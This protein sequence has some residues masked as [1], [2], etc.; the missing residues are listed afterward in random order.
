MSRT[1]QIEL[2]SHDPEIVDGTTGKIVRFIEDRHPHTPI[3]IPLPARSEK[4]GDEVSQRI[5]PR[6]IEVWAADTELIVQM[7]QLNLPDG[8][9][10][11][12]KQSE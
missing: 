3:A 1:L 11:S 8:V 2:T 6:V 5:H 4:F 9:K 10:V 7:R 12:I